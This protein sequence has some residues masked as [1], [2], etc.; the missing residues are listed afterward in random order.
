VW[1]APVWQE[2]GF[3][4]I[5]EGSGEVEPQPKLFARE[6]NDRADYSQLRVPKSRLSQIS[7]S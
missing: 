6:T 3:F 7:A 5:K 2:Y 4:S 1:T